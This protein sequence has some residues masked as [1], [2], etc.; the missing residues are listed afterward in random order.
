MILI[1]VMNSTDLDCLKMFLNVIFV[2]LNEVIKYN[3]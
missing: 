3:D 2:Q 1:F